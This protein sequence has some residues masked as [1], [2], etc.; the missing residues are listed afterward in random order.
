MRRERTKLP[1]LPEWKSLSPWKVKFSMAIGKYPKPDVSDLPL[2]AL[3]LQEL[4]LLITNNLP[5]D[6]PQW[7]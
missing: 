6:D 2:T 1:E 3:I 4:T 7:L 5:V